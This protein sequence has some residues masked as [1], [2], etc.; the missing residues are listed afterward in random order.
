MQ[1]QVPWNI[2]TMIISFELGG[3]KDNFPF[4]RNMKLGTVTLPKNLQGLGTG[5]L[6]Q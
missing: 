4:L 2:G 5:M 1:T 3:I 6:D